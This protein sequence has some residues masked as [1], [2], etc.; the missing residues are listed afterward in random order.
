MSGSRL[1]LVVNPAAGGGTSADALSGAVRQLREAGHV[2]EVRAT[3]EPGEARR[4]AAAEA[5]AFDRVAACGGDGTISEVA[6]GLLESGARRPLVV[7]P[8]GTGND[9]A[10]AVGAGVLP[11]EALR[12]A[13]DGYEAPLDVGFAGAAPF[14]NAATAGVAAEISES[15]SAELKAALGPLAYLAS[16]LA[17]LGSLHGFE[18]RLQGDEGVFEGPLLFFAVANGQTV[19]GGTRVAPNARVDDGLLDLVILP[20]LPP[21][22]LLGAL[23]ALRV[24]GEHAGLVR[25]RGRR[26]S[27][28]TADEIAIS[29]D[30]EPL[31]AHALEF[32]VEP[33]AIALVVHGPA[34][35]RSD[36]TP[37][38]VGRGEMR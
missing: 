33:A 32:R 23:R 9:F 12:L 28:E 8:A 20:A 13:F 24:G 25:M 19:G 7:V 29:C 14:V 10:T 18:A 27:F 35:A 4:I 6:A 3:S 38:N 16:G 2:V 37:G 15:A 26:F 30:G 11:E 22:T 36:A 21:A 17:R 5:A 1:L 34:P 31:R